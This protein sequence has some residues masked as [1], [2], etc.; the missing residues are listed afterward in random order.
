MAQLEIDKHQ[1]QLT[2]ATKM[3]QVLV[4]ISPD[5]H[6][7]YVK[8]GSLIF[9]SRGNFYISVNA[10]KHQV[11]DQT[12]FTVSTASPIAQKLIGLK[13]NDSFTLNHQEFK[14]LKIQ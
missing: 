11:E 4:R 1:E 9:T 14:I 6:T 10:G 2:E 3:K 5:E 7:E 12:F 13:V 8:S